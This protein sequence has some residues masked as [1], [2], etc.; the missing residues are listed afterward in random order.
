LKTEPVIT[1]VRTTRPAAEVGKVTVYA[2]AILAVL[3][4]GYILVHAMRAYVATPAVNANRAS[5]RSAGL[6]EVRATAEKELHGDSV[7]I[8]KPNNVVRLPIDRAMQLVVEGGKNPQAFRS[9]FLARLEKA[10]APPPKPP[11]QSLE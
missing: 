4:I 9:N 5:E 1:E 3:L 11:S 2:V 10:S 8:N 6:A 7:Y